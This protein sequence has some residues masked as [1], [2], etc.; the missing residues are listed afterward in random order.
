MKRTALFLAMLFLCI[1][2]FPSHLEM[3]GSE[4]HAYSAVHFIIPAISTEFQ[5]GTAMISTQVRND[6]QQADNKWF[7]ILLY[8][9]VLLLC[10]S[11]LFWFYN[12]DRLVPTV[13]AYSPEISL[14]IGGHA[15]PV[16]LGLKLYLYF[17]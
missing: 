3:P 2:L 4:R 8:S 5:S 13:L 17:L 12:N 15:P 14:R 10:S 7:N 9:N 6:F 16:R 1:A 11:M